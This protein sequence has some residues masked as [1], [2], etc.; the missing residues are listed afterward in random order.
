MAPV[1]IIPPPNYGYALHTSRAIYNF[2]KGII[3][4]D[5]RSSGLGGLREIIG[6]GVEITRAPVSGDSGRS[7]AEH[8][9]DNTVV[10]YKVLSQVSRFSKVGKNPKSGDAKTNATTKTINLATKMKEEYNDASKKSNQVKAGLNVINVLGGGNNFVKDTTFKVT[11]AGGITT[12]IV[13]SFGSVQNTLVTV[14][15]SKVDSVNNAA[16]Q[17]LNNQ[18]T[19]MNSINERNLDSLRKIYN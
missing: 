3:K 2:L 19:Q 1:G 7:T 12:T 6:S 8:P 14:P 11:S 16:S 10:P 15:A 5:T 9:E 17:S 4:K 18:K 13:S